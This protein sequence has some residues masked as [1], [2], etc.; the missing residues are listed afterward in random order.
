M[1]RVA[2][3]FLIVVSVVDGLSAVICGVL[4]IAGPDGHLLQAG[5]LLPVIQTLPLANVFFHN[6]I[7]I[8]AAMLL[9]LGLPNLIAALMLLR[10]SESQYAA[11]LVAAIL[12]VCWCGFEMVF[13]FNVPAVGYLVVGVLSALCSIFLLRPAPTNV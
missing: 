3:G 8:G 12:L 7:W 11:S 4:L 9:A 1:R 6:F 2:R 10:R 13:M 5:A